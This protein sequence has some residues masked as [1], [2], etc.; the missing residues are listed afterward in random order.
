[1]DLTGKHAFVTG[2]GKRLGRAMAEVLL[3]KGMNISAHFLNSLREVEDLVAW[4]KLNSLGRVIPLQADLRDMSALSSCVQRS[5]TLLGPI[6]L[7]INSASDFFPTPLHSTTLQEW[8]SLF[9]LNLK[10]P[11]FLT[12]QI[13]PHMPRGAQIIFIADVHGS[14]PI[15]HFSSYCATKAGLISLSKSLAKEL[16]PHIR[17]NSLSPGT[18]L[19]GDN[20]GALERAQA[21]KRTLLGRIGTPQ[22]LV[23]GLLFLVGNP[24]ITGFDLVID[25]G[26]SL[27]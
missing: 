12:Q 7:L 19:L 25:G 23:E 26:R 21:E 11:F 8:D 13:A 2:S 15:K 5:T 27:A 24:Y 16:A 9:E 17:V 14:R 20:A 10:A 6:D 3:Q 18:L 4:A 1:M 22:D